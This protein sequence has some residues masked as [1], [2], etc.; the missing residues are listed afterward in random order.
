LDETVGDPAIVLTNLKQWTRLWRNVAKMTRLRVLYL[1]V[2]SLYPRALTA[3]R[4]Q[5]LLEP[6]EALT[7]VR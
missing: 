3:E 1:N 2:D 5:K 7:Q 4:E 6:L